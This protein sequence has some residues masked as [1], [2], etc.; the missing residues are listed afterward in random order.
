M[1]MN[2]CIVV[3][4][5]CMVIV[6]VVVV[7]VII[8]GITIFF[9]HRDFFIQGSKESTTKEVDV[10]HIPVEVFKTL[11]LYFYIRSVGDMALAKHAEA[12]LALADEYLMSDL[13]RR[14]EAYLCWKVQTQYYTLNIPALLSLADLHKARVLKDICI[15]CVFFCGVSILGQ[16]G[17]EEL[18]PSLMLELLRDNATRRE[19]RTQ[20]AV[21]EEEDGGEVVTLPAAKRSRN[22]AA[23]KKTAV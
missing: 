7:V 10:S 8:I 14:C 21:V 9:L 2:F 4:S 12:L 18:S 16:K 6:V 15:E 17:F 13:F 23:G 11:H 22:A 19:I 5:L 1:L 20:F 3:V